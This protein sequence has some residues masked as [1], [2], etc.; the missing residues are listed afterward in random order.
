VKLLQSL[1]RDA[2][3][4]PARI[5]AT[6]DDARALGFENVQTHYEP[7]TGQHTVTGDLPSTTAAR[8]IDRILG[9]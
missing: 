6:A 7:A 5:A 2:P 3:G 8:T 9:R 4:A 1:H